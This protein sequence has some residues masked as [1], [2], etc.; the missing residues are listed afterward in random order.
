MLSIYYRNIWNCL[1]KWSIDSL[2]FTESFIK[3]WNNLC[4]TF[5]HTHSTSSAFFHIYISWFFSNLYLKIANISIHFN[6]FTICK[7][8]N[9]FML[10]H[11]NHFWSHNTCSTIQ[12]WECFIKFCHVSANR[13]LSFNKINLFPCISYLQSC[14]HTCNSTTNYKGR[15]LYINNSWS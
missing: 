1:R 14:L 7:K 8:L 12:S 6:N 4:W 10:T 15:L 9:I 11:G 3:L 5:F 13:R 2:S